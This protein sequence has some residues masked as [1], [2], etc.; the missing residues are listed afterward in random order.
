MCPRAACKGGKDKTG[1]KGKEKGD[2]GKG[3]GKGE[4]GKDGGKGGKKGDD[5]KVK[6]SQK[7]LF[8]SL[9]CEEDQ[10]FKKKYCKCGYF[11]SGSCRFTAETC[12]YS[13][14]N[15]SFEFDESATMKSNLDRFSQWDKNLAD[16]M[17]AKMGY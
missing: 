9:G 13:H 16:K 7:M 14:N 10:A 11:T 17:T 5:N 6:Y 2:K 4:P 15:E 12:I 3:K 1:G 8:F